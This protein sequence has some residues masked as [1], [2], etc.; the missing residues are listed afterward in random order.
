M[1][2][3]RLVVHVVDD[4]QLVRESLS[5]LLQSEGYDV[6]T[7]ASAT[8]FLEQRS[9]LAEPTCVVLDVMMPGMTGLELQAELKRLGSSMPLVFISGHGTIEKTAGALKEGATAF[10]EKPLDPDELLKAVATAIE[11]Y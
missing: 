10:L 6:S 4:D 2:R 8:A 3:Y 11:R 7:Y 5:R 9:D 1:K